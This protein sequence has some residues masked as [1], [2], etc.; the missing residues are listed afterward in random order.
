MEVRAKILTPEDG[1]SSLMM[2]LK[3]L[4]ILRRTVS[5][6]M[7]LTTGSRRLQRKVVFPPLWT[8]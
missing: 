6:G 8:L 2:S 5:T 4:H 1:F 3:S 7:N